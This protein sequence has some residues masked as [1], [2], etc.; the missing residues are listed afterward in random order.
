MKLTIETDKCCGAGQCVLSAPSAFDQDEDGIACLLDAEPVGTERA[1]VEEAV[2]S[3][4][5]GAI[6]LLDD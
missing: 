6:V 5:T 3:C 2:A 1:E 4:P